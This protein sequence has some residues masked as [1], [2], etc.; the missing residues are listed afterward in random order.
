MIEDLRRRYPG[1]VT[2]RFGDSDAMNRQLIALVR[3]GKKRATMGRLSDFGPGKEAKPVVGRCDII[4][5]WDGT[6][7]V[8]VRT[9]SVEEMPLNEIS[10][11]FALAEGE[12]ETY[13]EWYDDHRAYFERNGGWAPDMMM[14]CERFEVI[15]DLGDDPDAPG[16]VR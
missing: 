16:Y 12:N 13:G 10:E 3:A 4:T 11:D 8:V 15:E 6:P 2:F 5:Q 1:A 7:A 14:I 9:V